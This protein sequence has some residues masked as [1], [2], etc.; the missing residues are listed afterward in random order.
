MGRDGQTLERALAFLR[1]SLEPNA[2]D[3]RSLDAGWAYRTPAMPDVWGLNQLRIARP[4]TADEM[5]ALAEAHLAGLPYRHVVVEHDEIATELEPGLREH[6]W[7]VDRELLMALRRRLPK[8]QPVATVIEPPEDAMLG[9]MRRWLYEELGPHSGRT[10]DQLVELSRREAR[11]GREQCFGVA[12]EDGRLAAIT[13]LRSDGATAQI[14]D[15]YTA[16]EARR[17]GFATTL[18]AH[19]AALARDRDHELV[20]IVADDSDW[21]KHFYARLGFEPIGRICAFHLLGG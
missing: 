10:T 8:P 20:L 19:A 4:V 3:L 2:A 5:L 14:E 16:P 15:V 1:K 21:P 9:L 13:K 18:V 12:G 7:T 11:T 6:G 17:R